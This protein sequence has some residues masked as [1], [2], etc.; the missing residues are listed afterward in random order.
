MRHVQSI[1]RQ[2]ALDGSNVDKGD[3][4]KVFNY[5]TIESR[6]MFDHMYSFEKIPKKSFVV[7]NT[8]FGQLD[9]PINEMMFVMP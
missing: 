9:F 7:T 4:S 3:P 8:D 2:R 6:V 5:E 1:M